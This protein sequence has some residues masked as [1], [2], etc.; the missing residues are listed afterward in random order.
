VYLSN[1]W[2][3]TSLQR[4]SMAAWTKQ[5]T[6]T[7]GRPKQKQSQD[8]QCHSHSDNLKTFTTHLC[9]AG[10]KLKSWRITHYSLR[11]EHGAFCDLPSH[12]PFPNPKGW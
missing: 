4:L 5:K 11:G 6:I 7:E 10:S 9:F 3:C 8:Q 1:N 2:L 12:H